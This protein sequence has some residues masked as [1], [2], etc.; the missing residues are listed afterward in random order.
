MCVKERYLGIGSDRLEE[1]LVT[2]AL[3]YESDAKDLFPTR[4]ELKGY[5]FPYSNQ[6]LRKIAA[7][8]GMNQVISK[9]VSKRLIEVLAPKT[10]IFWVANAFVVKYYYTLP[11]GYS[12]HEHVPTEMSKALRANEFDERIELMIGIME[13]TEL[14][15]TMIFIARELG[16]KR[17]PLKQAFVEPL[18]IRIM[19]SEALDRAELFGA[20]AAG[21]DDVDLTLGDPFEDDG[22]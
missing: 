7:M 11:H 21:I 14:I 20:I 9:E 15:A 4:E 8:A 3:S 12:Y 2:L 13:R 10:D 18:L 16:R 1:I 5:G 17:K 22:K 6:A 19:L